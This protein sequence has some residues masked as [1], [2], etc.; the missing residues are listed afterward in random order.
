MKNFK[1]GKPRLIFLLLILLLFITFLLYNYFIFSGIISK[2]EFLSQILAVSDENE[3]P[4]FTIQKIIHYA[5]AE[6]ISDTPDKPLENISIHQFSD[7][8]VKIDNLGTITDLTAENTVQ[9]LYIDNIQTQ[10]NIGT[11]LFNYK[12]SLNFGKFEMIENYNDT[13]IDFN[14]VNTNTENET[15]DYSN[16][17]FF[18]DCSNP[19]TLG[20]LNKDLL[21]NY[22]ASKDSNTV[23]YNGKILEEAGIALEDLYTTIS[24]RIN[25]TNNKNEKFIYNMKLDLDLNDSNGS[26]YSGYQLRSKNTSG[27]E[28]R[29]FKQAY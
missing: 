8:S 4:I 25:L 23:T 28:Y 6:V 14:I 24:F 3:K 10:C 17:T 1:I 29:F 13:K 11:H 19:I 5:N 2:N 12:N 16:P 7:L 9:S 21:T 20:F 22:S 27:D 15:T 26:I 18:T